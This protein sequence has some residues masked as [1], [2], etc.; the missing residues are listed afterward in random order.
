M[1]TRDRKPRFVPHAVRVRILVGGVPS[2]R[3]RALRRGT[4]DP[5][6]IAGNLHA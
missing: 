1:E 5:E 6:T 3:D 2:P 4:V